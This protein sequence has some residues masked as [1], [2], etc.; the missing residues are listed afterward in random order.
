MA[1][2][3]ILD[4][5]CKSFRDFTAVDDVTMA[6]PE[7]QLMAL[8]GHNGAGKSTLIKLMLGLVTPSS[9]SLQV[10]GEDPAAA[11]ALKARYDVGY[12]PE[13]VMFEG[14]MTGRE[15][16]R[17]FSRLKR[18]PVEKS[19]ELFDLVG[20][21]KAVDKKVKTYSKGMR[22][23]LGL[24]QALIGDP[25]ILLLDEPTSGLDPAAQAHFYE[26]VKMLKAQGVSILIC[27]HALTEL[28]AQAD[29]VSMMNSG[30]LMACAPL[31]ELRALANLPTRISIRVPQGKAPD[32]AD[33]LSNSGEPAYVNDSLV[34]LEIE[35]DT[36]MAVLNRIS[37]LGSDAV[38]VDVHQPTLDRLY[39][40][41]C[42][43]E[44]N[45]Q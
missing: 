34:E 12:L 39:A 28:E 44:E 10:L 7:G 38:D 6:L 36:K 13:N 32:I 3:I 16:I 19:M 2:S 37:A 27:S 17:F 25:R 29:L 33:R 43:R 5:V 35:P 31:E 1:D 8:V 4:R 14:N 11:S 20:L 24:A 22:Q 9:G 15:I 30:R 18:V 21:E 41:Y 23:R 40:S 45:G 26:L 42:Q